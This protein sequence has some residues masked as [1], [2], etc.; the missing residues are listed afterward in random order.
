M[1]TEKAV[2]EDVL[3]IPAGLNFECTGCGNC[4]LK[5]PVPITEQDLERLREMGG[6]KV[7]KFNQLFSKRF[8]MFTHYL[9]KLPDGRC[10]FLDT[11]NRC[12]L[13]TE[14]GANAKPAMCSLFPYTFCSTPTGTYASV[15]FAST[16][17]LLNS[18]RPLLE[19]KSL[20][21]EKLSLFRTLF[22]RDEKEWRSLQLIDGVPLSWESYL[23]LEERFVSNWFSLKGSPEEKILEFAAFVESQLPIRTDAEKTPPMESPP[24]LIDAHL[25]DLFSGFY[26]PE[27]PYQELHTDIDTQALM[28]RLVFAHACPSLQIA[29]LPV[30]IN[31]GSKPNGK[32]E[33]LLDRFVYAKLFSKLFFGPG[34]AGLSLLSGLHHLLI[35]VLLLRLGS[36]CFDCGDDENRAFILA[37][38]LVRTMEMRLT[39]VRY[40]PQSTM[41]LEVLLSSPTRARR[42]FERY[43]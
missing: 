29:G 30:D 5:W 1:Q 40:S 25:L 18:G 16:G 36:R 17:V 8:E 11:E 31:S 21:Q 34:F 15:S 7:T 41:I 3:H 14:Y 35:V 39:D 13:H 9:N 12:R 4:C 19:Q 32:I 26:L 27:N 33:N 38:E 28:K 2:R 20:L 6:A 37:C 23:G 42:V 24:E 43:F 10:E 22:V